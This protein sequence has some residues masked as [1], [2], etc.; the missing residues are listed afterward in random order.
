MTNLS[1]DI[2]SLMQD[3]RWRDIE[4]IINNK[5]EALMD[6]RTIDTTQPAEH[7]KAEVIARRIAY[8]SLADFLNET[9]LVDRKITK[10]NNP[11]K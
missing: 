6:F 9:L 1:K 11:F 2:L 5:I 8:D 7:V 3:P 10:N 4:A